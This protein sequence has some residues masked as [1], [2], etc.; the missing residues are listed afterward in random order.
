[1]DRVRGIGRGSRSGARSTGARSTG[2]LATGM[3]LALMTLTA[4]PATVAASSFQP[5]EVVTVPSRADAVRVGDV[6]GDGRADVVFTTGYNNDPT[7]D[8]GLF[9]MA[10]LA[11]GTLAAPVRYATAGSYGQRPSSL[12]LGDVTGDGRTDVVVGLDRYGIQVFPG[13]A[14]GTL[15]APTL[16]ASTDST[17]V[18][19]G[20][21]DAAPGLDVAGIGWGSNTVTVFSGG[22][23]GLSPVATYPAK[24]GG[25]DDLEVGD[26][27][28]DGLADIVVMS[29]Q[30]YADP[31]ISVLAQ[32]GGG[33]F[34]AAA[35]YSIGT[36]I[37][38][39]GIGLGD[40]T[41]DG[42]VDVVA[43]YG[44]NRPYSNIAVFAQ[45][46][47]G[48]LAAAVSSPSYDIPQPVEVAD[49][50]KDGRADV[51]TMHGGW[52][53]AGIYFGQAGGTLAAESLEVVPYASQYNVQGL[54]IGD[55][56]GN[57][58]S[59]IV[60]ADSNYGIVILFNG[61][62]P[63]PTAPGAP[64]LT[65]AT[66]ANGAVSVAWSAPS[67]DGGSAVT[68]YM[69]T[70]AP[71]GASCT[72]ASLGCTILGL[73][74]GT[75]YS[76]TVRATNAVGTGPASNALMATPRTV[77]TA[78][79]S[80]TAKATGTGVTLK[81]SAPSSNGGAAISGYRVY[82]GSSSTSGVVLA[83]VSGGT[84]TF[85]DTGAP[86]KATSYYWVTALNSAG[87]S[88]RSNVVSVAR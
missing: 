65:S 72:T 19:L 5:A 75:S 24:H 66:P 64:T 20:S 80:L 85:V 8:F 45:T 84:L 31:N 86:R 50:D 26:V 36:N 47:S 12:A 28:D 7:N 78:P 73:A 44:G 11:D 57:G 18:A 6:T 49:L 46:A 71:G 55:V 74:N 58:L 37:L 81:W 79:R 63:A 54:A 9:V 41:G 10:Q 88:A 87:E 25:Y 42:R 60:E 14:G 56:D 76:I 39:S 33:G 53:R 21:L 3:T 59:D 51:V 30:L 83:T 67:S 52:Q 69:A 77:P 43:S 40:V 27:S 82:R 61:T 62:R 2:A 16:T 35:E 4:G 17:R 32:L 1:M 13:Q 22:A 34:A 23:A 48:T 70:A 68:S 15:G 38:T 29:G